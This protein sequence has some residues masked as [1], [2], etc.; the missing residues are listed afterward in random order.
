MTESSKL[1]IYST[2]L[3]RLGS[4]SPRDYIKWVH[5]WRRKK[6]VIIFIGFHNPTQT[7][8]LVG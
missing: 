5:N 7:E 3:S 6:T 4:R 1:N 8:F 2:A